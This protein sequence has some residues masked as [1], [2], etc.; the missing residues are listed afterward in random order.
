MP[1]IDLGRIAYI[2]KGK[3]NSSTTYE[4]KDVVSYNG[5][6]W[7]SLINNNT[8]EVPSEGESWA[9]MSKS[10]YQSWLDQGNTG[11]EE[12]FIAAITPVQP[13]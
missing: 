13:D 11:T 4:Q 5:S 10:T 7:A 9:L 6:S 12:D 8:N 1:I 2:N 3:W